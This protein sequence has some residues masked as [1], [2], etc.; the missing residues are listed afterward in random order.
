[1]RWI[2]THI[3]TKMCVCANNRFRSVQIV[4]RL[5]ELLC[6]YFCGLIAFKSVEM[7]I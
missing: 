1:M 6:K 7:R 2:L 4:H 5:V 3:H